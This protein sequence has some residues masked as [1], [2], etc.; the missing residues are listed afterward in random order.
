MRE[1]LIGSI[2]PI[3][4][5]ASDAQRVSPLQVWGLPSG[6]IRLQPTRRVGQPTLLKVQQ[7]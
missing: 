4:G 2:Q 1:G 6:D 5:V 3:Q 7:G